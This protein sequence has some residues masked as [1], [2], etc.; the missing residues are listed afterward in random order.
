MDP[1]ANRQEAA[2][3]VAAMLD[4]ESEHID[5]GDAVRLAEL[6]QAFAEWRRK[7]GCDADWSEV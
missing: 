4:P 5:T 6:D 7:G 1:T 2:A 3:I